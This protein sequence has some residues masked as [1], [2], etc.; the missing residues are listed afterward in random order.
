MV[1]GLEYLWNKWQVAF[2]AVTDD[3][4][5][6]YSMISTGANQIARFITARSVISWTRPTPSYE[7]G[8]KIQFFSFPFYSNTFFCLYYIDWWSCTCLIGNSDAWKESFDRRIKTLFLICKAV[9]D[10]ESQPFR[11]KRRRL[12]SLTASKWQSYNG[13]SLNI[14]IY[15]CIRR[16]NSDIGIVLQSPSRLLAS[17][18]YHATHSRG[19][20]HS[21]FHMSCS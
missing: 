20:S 13:I 10:S 1:T 7:T 8:Q 18:H 19:V 16:V 4:Q 21:S 17:Y 6:F 12:S 3:G 11:T 9:P 5:L 15:D 2:H 14:L